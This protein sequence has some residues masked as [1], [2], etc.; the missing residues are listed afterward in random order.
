[1][2]ASLNS[3]EAYKAIK[4]SGNHNNVKKAIRLISPSWGTSFYSIFGIGKKQVT[5]NK[6]TKEKHWL[7]ALLE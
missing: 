1:M 6:N 7:V 5:K 4:E 2:T 3:K